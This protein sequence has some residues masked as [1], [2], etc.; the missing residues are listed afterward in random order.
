MPNNSPG[1]VDWH[2]HLLPEID[3]GP[4]SIE[5]AL[6]M[7]QILYK[8]GYR[9]VCCTPHC[10]KGSYDATSDDVRSAVALLQAELDRAGIQ[11]VLLAGREYYLDEFLFDF[12]NDPL[13][14]G[15]SK[16]LLL[17]IPVACNPIFI[18]DT[19]LQLTLRG[20][21]PVI[22]HVERCGALLPPRAMK[23]PGRDAS[24]IV[25]AITG[26]YRTFFAGGDRECCYSGGPEQNPA[27]ELCAHLVKTGIGFQGNI[28]SLVGLYGGLVQQHA[29]HYL[30]SG[31]Y[32]HY[33]SDA[34]SSANLEAWLFQ[35]LELVLGATGADMSGEFGLS[36]AGR[37][38][39]YA[40][41]T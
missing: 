8:A 7:A 28:G 13:T 4:A 23:K 24:T 6:Q 3:D 10:I 34:H 27:A 26:W 25:S 39:R 31:L 37:G 5:E 14:L 15:D 16:Y 33:G 9:Q 20:Y 18:R 11:L 21:T 22:A 32:T 1:L 40:V 30:A 35:G 38:N 29:R 19:C 41:L 36:A 17:E 2:C 12:L